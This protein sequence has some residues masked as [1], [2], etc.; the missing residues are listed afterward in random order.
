MHDQ[1]DRDRERH[2]FPGRRRRR[3]APARPPAGRRVTGERRAPRGAPA[4][5]PSPAASPPGSGRRC[6]R[7]SADPRPRPPA[8]IAAPSTSR[9]LPRIDPTSEALTTSWRPSASAKIAMI[10]SGALPKVTFT[11]PAD[12]GARAGR[13]L[14]GGVGSSA[15][16]IGHDRQR[17]GREHQRRRRR[18]R[19]R[20]AAGDGD[21]GAEKVYRPHPGRGYRPSPTRPGAPARPD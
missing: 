12:A 3:G 21:E 8:S 7:R 6:G 19:G 1:H 4:P 11:R 13:E 14:L 16:P 2:R 18:P 10:S 15:P 20:S 5:P 17:R 9:Q